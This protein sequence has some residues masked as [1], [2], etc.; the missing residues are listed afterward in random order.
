[1]I[2]GLMAGGLASFLLAA[3]AI[4]LSCVPPNMAQTFNQLNDVPEPYALMIG[5]FE[6][7]GP[8]PQP[9][10]G[11]PMAANFIF[12]G[13]QVGQGFLAQHQ[14]WPVLVETKCLASWCGGFPQPRDTM[15]VFLEN[16]GGQYVYKPGPC[17]PMAKSWP[18]REQVDAVQRCMTY[19]E[20]GPAEVSVF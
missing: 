18:S 2:R 15:M 1:M 17:D 6:P 16:R 10:P 12:Q 13:S 19:G 4:A 14:H 8:L 3:E 5:T 7:T 20:C 9:Q 11:V